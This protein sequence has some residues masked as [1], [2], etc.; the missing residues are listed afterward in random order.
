MIRVSVFNIPVDSI[1]SDSYISELKSAGVRRLKFLSSKP[2]HIPTTNPPRDIFYFRCL[3]EDT[4]QVI[5]LSNRFVATGLED[6][7]CTP[8][9]QECV[10]TKKEIDEAE[11]LR[12]RINRAGSGGWD[13]SA[14]RDIDYHNPRPDRTE[15]WC[16][17]QSNYRL[18]I[19]ELPK[20]PMA[21]DRAYEIVLVNQKVI[22]LVPVFRSENALLDPIFNRR[23]GDQTSWFQLSCKRRLPPWD[24]ETTGLSSE[25]EGPVGPFGKTGLFST[26]DEGMEIV[27]RRS[28]MVKSFPNKLPDVSFAHELMGVWPDLNSDDHHL[29]GTTWIVSQQARSKLMNAGVTHLIYDPVRILE[30]CDC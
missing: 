26:F 3:A 8:S 23:S 4:D 10:W 20:N 13:W 9:R 2:N 11:L 17:Q 6:R 1:R 5:A 19:G 22:D 21:I 14:A 28:E 15:P 30:D 29:P 16:W 18:L 24:E 27:Y 7:F 12:V 25:T